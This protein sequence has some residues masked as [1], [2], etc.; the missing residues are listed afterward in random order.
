MSWVLQYN[1]I[2]TCWKKQE[3]KGRKSTTS[4]KSLPPSY[5][6]LQRILLNCLKTS[7][8]V[9]QKELLCFIYSFWL[10]GKERKSCKRRKRN[11]GLASLSRFYWIITASN[12]DVFCEERKVLLSILGFQVEEEEE[13]RKNRFVA[14]K[15]WKKASWHVWNDAEKRTVGF[16]RVKGNKKGKGFFCL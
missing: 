4:R 14:V 3:K 15:L 2:L 11:L 5:S 12:H 10:V 6:R 8:W 16:K 13:G 9:V 7:I 1:T